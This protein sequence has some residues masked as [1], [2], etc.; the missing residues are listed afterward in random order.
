MTIAFRHTTTSLTIMAESWTLRTKELHIP[1]ERPHKDDYTKYD[2]IFERIWVDTPDT[3]GKIGLA[4]TDNLMRLYRHQRA[5]NV[6]A[7]PMITMNDPTV[8]AGAGGVHSVNTGGINQGAP[9]FQFPPDQSGEV[10]TRKPDPMNPQMK[11]IRIKLNIHDAAI[12]LHE[13]N[14][15]I[16]RI[17]NDGKYLQPKS[18][19]LLGAV[20][21]NINMGIMGD[22]HNYLRQLQEKKANEMETYWL[23]CCDAAKYQFDEATIKTIKVINN[24]NL[25]AAGYERVESPQQAKVLN[26]NMENEDLW[27]KV[28]DINEV[29]PTRYSHLKGLDDEPHTEPTEGL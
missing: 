23:S 11:T 28:L 10:Y 19:E 9:H 2:V 24:Q 18:Q 5:V 4:I 21:Q 16:H 22:R 15:A 29:D 17:V 13:V 25:V 12:F 26:D 20:H 27:E 7:L 8:P 14:H 1:S 3:G 6:Q